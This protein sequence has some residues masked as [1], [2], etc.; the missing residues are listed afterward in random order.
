MPLCRK[1][2][3]GLYEVRSNLSQTKQIARLVFFHPGENLIV[4]EGFIKKTQKTPDAVL[5]QAKRRKG[6]YERKVGK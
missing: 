6:E 5:M 1:L 3:D 4:V 2:G